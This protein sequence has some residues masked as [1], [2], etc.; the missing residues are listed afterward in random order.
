M[1]NRLNLLIASVLMAGAVFAQ[2]GNELIGD[3][4]AELMNYTGPEAPAA[5]ET[6][7]APADVSAVVKPEA[8]PKVEQKP[9]TVVKPVEN[10]AAVEDTTTSADMDARVEETREMFR[11]GDF[12]NAVQGLA[13]LIK[14][15][16]E[17]PAARRYLSTLMERDHRTVEIDG[18]NAVDAAWSTELVLR[19]YALT[20]GAAKR[21]QLGSEGS[22]VDVESLFPQVNFPEAASAIYQPQTE[23]IFVN[24]TP[25]NLAV[26]E[27]ML[28]TMGVLRG[29]SDAEQVEI[30][31][32]FVEV[33]EGTLE[34][35]G[36][37]WNFEDPTT[38]GIGGSDLDVND[39]GN[40]LFSDAL[41]ASASGGMVMTDPG[42]NT[43]LPTIPA[44]FEYQYEGGSLPFS[45]TAAGDGT[46]DARG[47]WS[48]FRFADTFSAEPDTLE[49]QYAGGNPFD[50]VISALDQSS[51][52]D[53]LSAP[54]ILTRNG[55]EATI[56]VG[57]L[58]NFPEVYEGDA[59]QATIV[60]VSYED[61][62][63]KLLGVELTVTP[64][65]NN[66]RQIML[67]LNPRITELAGW[68][69]YQLA[70]ADYIYNYYQ[71]FK[72]P[73]SKFVHEPVIASLPIFKTREIE[74]TVTIADG[75]TIGMG[76][77]INEKSE[78]FEDKVPVLGSLPLVGRL[79]RNEGERVV[80]RNLLMFVTAK[81]VEPNGRI[82]TTRSFE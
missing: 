73:S 63:E 17:N 37:Q 26:M 35:L 71:E 41:R 45:Q 79:F 75:S 28:E 60:H 74:T 39:G 51:G 48:S 57:E 58:H 36:F 53:V 69:T 2:Q 21:M 46:I 67:E 78:A 82:S 20:D 38:I 33:S 52:A 31:A 42:D 66:K 25:E 34:E 22:T 7:Q 81:I 5:E 19:T 24:N 16:P 30:E 4:L 32:K 59:S 6:A 64:K 72:G 8:S 11:T 76:G 29:Y 15:A 50:V 65:V 70:P 44:V 10:P 18:M 77:L 3:I 14:I 49:L 43:V 9:A 47:D 23:T 61:F 55:Q 62:S 13:D 80:K 68:Q 27:A 54:R 12:T 40:G 56:Q 1:R